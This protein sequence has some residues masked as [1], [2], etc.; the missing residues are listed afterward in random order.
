MVLSLSC[1]VLKVITEVN[2]FSFSVRTGTRLQSSG[3]FPVF[4]EGKYLLSVFRRGMILDNTAVPKSREPLDAKGLVKQIVVM[5][6]ILFC[7][8]S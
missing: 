6:L 2:R 5:I 7:H 8:I 3:T 1:L 4:S